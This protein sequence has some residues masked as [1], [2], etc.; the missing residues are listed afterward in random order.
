MDDLS[1]ALTGLWPLTDGAALRDELL[2]AYGHPD[3]GY[4]DQQHLQQ[5]LA[6][7]DELAAAA[8]FD[9]LP[10]RLAAWF[11]DS[12]YDGER[13][14]EERSAA[15]AETSLPS[16]VDPDVVTETARLVRLTETHRPA[17]ADGNGCVL[18]DADLAI[19]A[20]EPKQYAAYVA[21]VRDEYG[22]L[23]DEVFNKGRIAVLT[24]LL[25][26]PRLFHTPQACAWWEQA[27]RDNVNAELAARR[28][29]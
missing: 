1:D 7:I 9:A 6:R 10:V 14:A 27:A 17:D 2:S 5:V 24:S 20:A 18:S 12:V 28:V 16:L 3:R 22:H 15:W 11:H 4:H 23:P 19:L 26:K 25:E 13:D 8:T 29:P 21:A